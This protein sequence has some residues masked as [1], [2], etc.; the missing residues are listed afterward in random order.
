MTDLEKGTVALGKAMGVYEIND[1]KENEMET[2]KIEDENGKVYEFGKPDFECKLHEVFSGLIYG[3][4]NNLPARWSLDDG[5]A[6]AVGSR[7]SSID[8]HNLTPIKPKWYEDESNFPALMYRQ[9]ISDEEY[10]PYVTIAGNIAG[11]KSLI[12]RSSMI[13]LATKEEVESLYYEGK[14]D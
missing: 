7:Y 11:Y 5:E 8:K 14:N 12:V 9:D 3:R 6:K 13:R 10:S 4:I 1:T 2:L